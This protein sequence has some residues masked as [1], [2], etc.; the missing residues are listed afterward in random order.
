[1]LFETIKALCDTNKVTI[2]QLERAT[3]I[4]NGTISRWKRASPSSDSLIKVADYFGVSTDYLLGR[5]EVTLSPE[6]KIIAVTFDSLPKP[7]RDLVRKYI[8]IIKGN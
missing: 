8:E 4:A 5:N 3:C 7:Q 2:A 1:M 6:S